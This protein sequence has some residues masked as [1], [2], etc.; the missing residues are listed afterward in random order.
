LQA[1]QAPLQPALQQTPST[2]F[3]VVHSFP[4]A[5]LDP[6]AFLATHAVTEQ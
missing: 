5:Q 6:F 2:Q 4:A 3:P 1:S